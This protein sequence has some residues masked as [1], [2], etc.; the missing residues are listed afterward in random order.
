MK[1]VLLVASLGLTA[2]Q[3]TT[4]A[5][6]AAKVLG[7]LEHCERTYIASIGGFGV[8]AGSLNIRCPARAYDESPP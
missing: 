7:N 5:E 4:S 6:T 1:V 3:S 2:C 8:P